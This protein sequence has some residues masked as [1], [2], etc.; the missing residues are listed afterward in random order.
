[1]SG[2]ITEPG[3]GLTWDCLGLPLY[4]QHVCEHNAAPVP[5][6]DMGRFWH[7]PACGATLKKRPQDEHYGQPAKAGGRGAELTP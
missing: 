3:W 4:A 1:M 6:L 2:W 7:C 5:A